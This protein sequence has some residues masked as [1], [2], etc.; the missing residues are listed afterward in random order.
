ML[1]LNLLTPVGFAWL[2]MIATALRPSEAL[3]TQWG[4]IDLQKKL[5]TVAAARMKGREGK[6]KP[7]VVPLS[8]LAL[9]VLE[10]RDRRVRAHTGDKD[11]D[12]AADAAA[13]VF[14]GPNGAPPSHT[15]FA[16]SPWK[17]GIKPLLAG[18]PKTPLGT[19]HSWRSIFRD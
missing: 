14:A 9:E 1:L 3:K 19:P 6:T 16:L 13:F 15:F 4:E 5:A 18:N 12:A 17:A 7:H 11:K 2:F 8:A 10:R